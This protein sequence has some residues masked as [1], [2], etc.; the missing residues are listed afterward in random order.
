MTGDFHAKVLVV[1]L[2]NAFKLEGKAGRRQV[3]YVVLL[4]G[5]V[6]IHSYKHLC[7]A[8]VSLMT[9]LGIIDS[10]KEF[11]VPDKAKLLI[12]LVSSIFNT[13]LCPYL[14]PTTS[15]RGLD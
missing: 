7:Q 8:D 6:S 5:K 4:I 12:L 10:F 11:I 15:H 13:C 3:S 2:S 1:I 14:V 9:S